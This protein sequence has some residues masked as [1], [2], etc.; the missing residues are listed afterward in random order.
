VFL[1]KF[2]SLPEVGGN[3]AYYFDTFD[4][5]HMQQVFAAGMQDYTDNNRSA[6]IIAHANQFTW[7][8]AAKQYLALYTELT[9]G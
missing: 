9:T 3:A 8:N 2:T 1:S 5:V 4:P 6:S 7:E